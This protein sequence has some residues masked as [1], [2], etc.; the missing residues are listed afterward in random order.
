MR[1]IL[2]FIVLVFLFAGQLDAQD[3]IYSKIEKRYQIVFKKSGYHIYALCQKYGAER[4]DT[5]FRYDYGAY[6]A[7]SVKDA[8]LHENVFM[9]VYS[10]MDG[11]FFTNYSY[12]DGKWVPSLGGFLFFLAQGEKDD[13]R[14]SIISKEKVVL[15]KGKKGKKISICMIIKRKQL[16]YYAISEPRIVSQKVCL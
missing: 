12:E 6:M 2:L 14:A 3:T 10:S 1:Q 5:V 13:Y 9:C 11:V 15:R 16:R 7:M 4:S 8:A